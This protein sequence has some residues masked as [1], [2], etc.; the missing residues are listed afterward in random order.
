[1]LTQTFSCAHCGSTDLIRNGHAP[2]GKLRFRCRACHK[3]GRQDPGSNAYDE[4][5]KALILS[6]Y[7]ERPSL[8]GISRIF[9]V[10][11]NTVSAW[12]KKSQCVARIV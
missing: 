10:S 2:N 11:R 4:K 5:T 7:H 12:L 8:R 3:Y 1:M 6:A 9:G